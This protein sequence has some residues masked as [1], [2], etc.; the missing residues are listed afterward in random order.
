MMEQRPN[1]KSRQKETP[2]PL[3]NAPAG[4]G[5]SSDGHA[6]ARHWLANPMVWAAGGIFALGTGLLCLLL[7]MVAQ[8]STTA[9]SDE[10]ES[11]RTPPLIED[12]PIPEYG[13]YGVMEPVDM[14]E[15]N[16]IDG[17]ADG[18]ESTAP[19]VP[20]SDIPL[21][22]DESPFD[23][24]VPDYFDVPSRP[25]TTTG[26]S[27]ATIPEEET[28]TSNDFLREQDGIPFTCVDLPDKWNDDLAVL[29][30]LSAI[31]DS[32]TDIELIHYHPQGRFQLTKADDGQWALD[33]FMTT[34]ND[35]KRCGTLTASSEGI[36]IEIDA[37][38]VKRRV[39]RGL[40]YCILALTLQESTKQYV[41][42]KA[43]E[44]LSP[45]SL[46]DAFLSRTETIPLEKLESDFDDADERVVAMVDMPEDS[47]RLTFSQDEGKLTVSFL[48]EVPSTPIGYYGTSRPPAVL[49]TA[50]FDLN[51]DSSGV[52]VVATDFSKGVHNLRESLA[53]SYNSSTRKALANYLEFGNEIQRTDPHVPYGVGLLPEVTDANEEDH[54]R[55][56][57]LFL[58]Y[59]PAK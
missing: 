13:D 23:A 21:E 15:G 17:M 41:Q 43:P 11:P 38:S 8:N 57:P 33:Y 10:T 1:E 32:I 3:P 34:F 25:A 7:F 22:S 54:Q 20:V 5:K 36:T 12:T 18:N 56:S 52:S 2:P 16:A 49:G 24:D 47:Q 55:T 37:A 48:E 46:K 30:E 14:P 28:L 9:S 53:R 26:T 29:D 27:T 4:E 6:D 44:E 58:L 59:Q 50:Y 40:P 35:W 45:I 39:V 31:G 42:L 51:V 19:T